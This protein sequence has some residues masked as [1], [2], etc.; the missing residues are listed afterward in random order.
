MKPESERFLAGMQTESLP[1]DLQ[2]IVKLGLVPDT[3]LPSSLKLARQV[4]PYDQYRENIL[5]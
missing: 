3:D 2:T 5:F 1:P 4:S